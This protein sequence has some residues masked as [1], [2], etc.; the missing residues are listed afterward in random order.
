MRYLAA[1]VSLLVILFACFLCLVVTAPLAHAQT[2]S[3]TLTWTAVGDDS[4]TGTASRYQL[5]WAIA[6][7]TATTPAALET[8]WQGA[9]QV[10]GLPAPLV[11]GTTQS[12]SIPGFNT[13][14]YYF[15][16]RAFDEANNVSGYGNIAV[17]S[18]TDA[19]RPAAIV[20]LR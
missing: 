17:K 8:W 14:T 3:I 5:R 9:A 6:A 20:D 15:M 13:G 16:L 7:P 10:T 1:S 19:I 11:A 12:M 18:V 4:L 2:G